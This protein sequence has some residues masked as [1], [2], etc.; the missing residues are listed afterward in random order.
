MAKVKTNFLEII[1]RGTMIGKI[2]YDGET[3]ILI[4]HLTYSPGTH[5]VKVSDN[6]N[7]DDPSANNYKFLLKDIFEFDY[8]DI[9]IIKPNNKKVKGKKNR[10]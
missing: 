5:V 10:K 2:I 3:S 8:E 6:I 4:N 7:P 1:L 9:K